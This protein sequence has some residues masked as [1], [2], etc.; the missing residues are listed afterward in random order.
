MKLDALPARAPLRPGGALKMCKVF[1]GRTLSTLKFAGGQGTDVLL[2][3]ISMARAELRNREQ[4][5]Q[6]KLEKA[7]Y[8]SHHGL[9]CMIRNFLQNRVAKGLHGL[10]FNASVMVA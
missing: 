9:F 2:Q 5:R 3:T 4:A 7:F 8:R 10:D 6:R 1:A